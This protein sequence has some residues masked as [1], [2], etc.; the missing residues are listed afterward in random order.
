MALSQTFHFT[1][2]YCRLEHFRIYIIQR[3][4]SSFFVVP[5]TLVDRDSVL[6]CPMIQPLMSHAFFSMDSS[7]CTITLGGTGVAQWTEQLDVR[8]PLPHHT[9]SYCE[10]PQFCFL[11]Q[12]VPNN[13][14][15][16]YRISLS[17]ADRHQWN[18]RAVWWQRNLIFSI[19]ALPIKF[20]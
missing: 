11:A 6:A 15:L 5:P 17:Y 10:C 8:S 20:Y 7:V 3:L 4:C 2:A 14:L 16:Y 18:A 9:R 1:S 19:T 12:A 13:I